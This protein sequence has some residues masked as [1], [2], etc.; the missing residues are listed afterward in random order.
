MVSGRL[1][2]AKLAVKVGLVDDDG[3]AQRLPVLYRLRPYHDIVL[4]GGDL[5]PGGLANTRG[6]NAARF[7][8]F[9]LRGRVHRRTR[10]GCLGSL[11]RG[12]GCGDRYRG[13][14]LHTTLAHG[15]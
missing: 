8:R 1:L 13:A 11:V 2:Q 5:A 9:D 6:Q 10:E 14:T 7:S 4:G 15:G 12:G 3:V